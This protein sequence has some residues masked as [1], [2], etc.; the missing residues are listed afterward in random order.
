MRWVGTD[1]A[2]PTVLDIRFF[3]QADKFIQDGVR[4][5][6]DITQDDI[7]ANSS[8]MAPGRKGSA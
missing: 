4:K 6:M 2:D 7:G 3:G 8:S 1:F 5:M